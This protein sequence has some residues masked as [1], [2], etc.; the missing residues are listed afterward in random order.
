MIGTMVKHAGLRTL[1]LGS[2]L[3]FGIFFLLYIFVI[4]IFSNYLLF[5]I[6]YF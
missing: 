5:V 1:V 3:D 6:F 2:S 4:V